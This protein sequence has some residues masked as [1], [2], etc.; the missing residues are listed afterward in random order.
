MAQ[1]PQRSGSRLANAPERWMQNMK[2]KGLIDQVVA[3]SR[4]W[5][6]TTA[7][8]KWAEKDL[9]MIGA[10]SWRL[11]T[12]TLRL[13]KYLLKFCRTLSPCET[14][15]SA[16]LIL[17]NIKSSHLFSSQSWITQNHCKQAQRNGIYKIQDRKDA[18]HRDYRAILDQIDSTNRN[19]TEEER[20]SPKLLRLPQSRRF[21]R[22]RCISDQRIHEGLYSLSETAVFSA[23]D[24]KSE[25]LQVKIKNKDWHVRDFT[26]QSNLYRFLRMTFGLQI[27]PTVFQQTIGV[28]FSR[29]NG[30]LHW[31]IL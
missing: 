1:S 18:L 9:T 20:I 24:A 26:S 22:A 23:L 19:R 30:S 11:P 3:K 31:F 4:S 25:H 29:F 5:E 10:I 21:E 2:L 28:A 12:L 13:K 8:Q 27:G 14:V 16:G 7:W 6:S 15:M 17:E